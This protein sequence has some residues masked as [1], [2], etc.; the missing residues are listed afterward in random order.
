MPLYGVIRAHTLMQRYVF[1]FLRIKQK[2]SGLRTPIGGP[3][4]PQPKSPPF[5]VALNLFKNNTRRK[6]NYLL[7]ARNLQFDPSKSSE[8]DSG[9]R[10]DTKYHITSATSASALL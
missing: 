8:I 4:S 1:S 6:K 10:I 9:Q 2:R 5:H 7:A 3:S